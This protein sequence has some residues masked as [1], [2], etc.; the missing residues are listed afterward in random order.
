MGDRLTFTE[1]LVLGYGFNQWRLQP[2]DGTPEG[3]FAPTNTRPAGPAPVGGDVQVAAF[4]VLNYFLTFTGP[5][6]RGARSAEQFEQQAGKIVPAI[7]AL[8]AEIVTLMEIEDT[9]ST[10]YSPGNADAA[11][12]DL[13][14]R[15]DAAAG[16]E[17]WAFVPLPKELYGA[18]RDVIRNAIIYQPGVVQPVGGP[19]GL[20]DESVWFNAREPIAQTF[21]QDG[22]ALTVVANHFKSK[23]PG[24]PTGDNVDSG[25][26]QGQWNGDRVRQAESLA[27]FADRLRRRSRDPDVLLLGDFN[28]YTQEDPI[29]K[30]RDAGFVDL[31]ELLDPGRYSYVFDDH[32]GSLDH[33]LASRR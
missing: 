14:R 4:N 13:V 11:L 28:A 3:V 8:G 31:G 32:S 20:V 12:A 19:I 24:A 5:D 30:L 6:A 25:D 21:S 29:E 33:A 18:D 1:S 26:G 10:G 9:D 27:A 22:D 15:L 23:S 2:A 16:Y 17:K 7:E